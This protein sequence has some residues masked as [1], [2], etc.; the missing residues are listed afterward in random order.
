[1]N[2]P[3]TNFQNIGVR[4]CVQKIISVHSA[5]EDYT[6]KSYGIPGHKVYDVVEAQVGP[7]PRPTLCAIQDVDVDS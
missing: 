6:K 7:L 3:N 5:S 1:M 2:I 4:R